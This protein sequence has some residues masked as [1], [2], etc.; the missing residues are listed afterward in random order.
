MQILGILWP[1][2]ALVAL[3]FVVWF[4]MVFRRLRHMR[5]SPPDRDTFA[6]KDTMTRYFGAE[7]TPADNLANLFEVPVLYFVLVPLLLATR[8]ANDIQ[9]ILAW[10]FVALRCAHSFIHI[11]PRNIQARFMVYLASC[12]VL[13]AMW[14]GFFVDAVHAA[15]VIHQAMAAVPPTAL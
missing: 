4:T 7:N 5:T 10:L 8:S 6:S 13:V 1:T 12:V 14:I 9:V 2:F 3:V 11:G 15:V